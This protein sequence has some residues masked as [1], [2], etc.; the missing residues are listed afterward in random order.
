MRLGA[1]AAMRHREVRAGSLRDHHGQRRGVPKPSSWPHAC[2]LLLM[3]CENAKSDPR[4]YGSSRQGAV[5]I[6][7]RMNPPLG[8]EAMMTDRV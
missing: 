2:S 7:V 3:S 6:S 5:S 8:R 1:P 4:A